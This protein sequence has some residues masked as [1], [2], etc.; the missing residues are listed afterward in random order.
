MST[1]EVH[2][3]ICKQRVTH[4]KPLVGSS[5]PLGS[6][7]VLRLR[8]LGEIRDQR[9]VL[10]RVSRRGAHPLQSGPCGQNRA[11]EFIRGQALMHPAGGRRL[12]HY[13]LLPVVRFSATGGRRQTV[14][15]AAH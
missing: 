4:S 12:H 14:K 1:L 5:T 9:E 10:L 15:P 11:Q 3:P 2:V 7:I 6:A 8:T 13:L